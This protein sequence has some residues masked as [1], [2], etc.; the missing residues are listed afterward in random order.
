[1]KVLLQHRA[2][3][4]IPESED[5]RATLENWRACHDDFVFRASAAGRKGVALIALGP[6]AQ[7]RRK[8][9][10]VTSMSPQPIRL[11]ANFAPTPFELDGLR[12]ACVEAFWQRLRFPIGEGGRSAGVDGRGA[13]HS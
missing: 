2:T 4:L 3:V 1:M 7:A 11:I 6:H 13:R 8:P 10:N 5:E 9:I 12:Y